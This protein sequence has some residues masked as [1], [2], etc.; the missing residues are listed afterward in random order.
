H[1]RGRGARLTM[2]LQLQ[3]LSSAFNSLLAF[4]PVPQQLAVLRAGL[5]ELLIDL[6]KNSPKN[7]AAP[8]RPGST[9]KP[10]RQDKGG[11]DGRQLRGGRGGAKGQH[12]L[13]YVA[14]AA[15]T[16]VSADTVKRS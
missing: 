13:S 7:S 3:A 5:R 6:P 11:E 15:A 4:A 2:Q 10:E 8:R 9:P 12:N 16:G 14:L 1:I